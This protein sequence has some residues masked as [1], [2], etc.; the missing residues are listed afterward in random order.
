M[1][2]ISL[3][4]H[5]TLAKGSGVFKSS[6]VHQNHSQSLLAMQF[7]PEQRNF[8]WLK[9][10]TD[11]PYPTIEKEFFIKFGR[12]APSK[13]SCRRIHRTIS[14]KGHSKNN[15]AGRSGRRKSATGPAFTTAVLKD[16]QTTPIQSTRKRAIRLG[17]SARS[18]TRIHKTAGIRGYK[19]TSANSLPERSCEEAGVQQPPWP[20]P[21]STLPAL[22]KNSSE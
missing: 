4:S 13:K 15:N 8:I 11:T 3:S 10:E 22:L 20:Q 14:D 6:N 9:K 5:I 18:I 12:H 21:C 2:L 19:R 17:I 1:S 7:T 16:T